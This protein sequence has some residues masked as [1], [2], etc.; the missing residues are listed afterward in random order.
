VGAQQGPPQSSSLVLELQAI[1]QAI[2]SSRR[3][4][5][6]A[7]VINTIIDGIEGTDLRPHLHQ[8]EPA[9]GRPSS[10][11]PMPDDSAAA[12]EMAHEESLLLG[13]RGAV[14]R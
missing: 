4:T 1:M 8:Q 10:P 9:R 2:A 14:A 13:S 7:D 6:F 3:P 12:L 11:S 5:T